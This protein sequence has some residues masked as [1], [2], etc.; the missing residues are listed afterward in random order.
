MAFDEN[1][2]E[3]LALLKNMSQTQTNHL[4]SKNISDNNWDRIGFQTNNNNKNNS[5]EISLSE[6]LINK[7][8]LTH[9][10]LKRLQKEWND[11]KNNNKKG[12]KK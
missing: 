11:S 6:Q 5:K 10:L 12:R 4:K 1:Y 9:E 7:G 2:D 8:L 3:D